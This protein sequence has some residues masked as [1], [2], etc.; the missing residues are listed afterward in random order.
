[1]LEAF[2]HIA[3][4]EQFQFFLH[5]DRQRERD[6]IGKSGRVICVFD[7]ELQ[8]FRQCHRSSCVHIKLL[9]QT[10]CQHLIIRLV[11][12]GRF[13]FILM[14]HDLRTQHE[15]LLDLLCFVTLH[16]KAGNP[17]H[18]DPQQFLLNSDHLFDPDQTAILHQIFRLRLEFIGVTLGHYSHIAITVQSLIQHTYLHRIINQQRDHRSR[19]NNAVRQRKD[20]QPLRKIIFL[21]GI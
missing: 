11:D 14:I 19:K 3:F 18:T 4:S 6:Q 16:G 12:A 7:H 17:L 1:M 15:R 8:I 10:L 5:R 20:P 21:L 2:L 13:V 9:R